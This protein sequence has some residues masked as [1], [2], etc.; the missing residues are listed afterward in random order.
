MGEEEGAVVVEVEGVLRF[1][2]RTREMI[3]ALEFKTVVL[4]LRTNL[5]WYSC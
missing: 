1:E 5:G 4:V 2:G 3:G